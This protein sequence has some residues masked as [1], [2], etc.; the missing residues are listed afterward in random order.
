MIDFRLFVLTVFKMDEIL[1]INLSC[2][3][4]FLDFILVD[5]FCNS[6]LVVFSTQQADAI[7]KIS[8]LSRKLKLNKSL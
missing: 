3:V 5:E 7:T 6:F 4:Y 2:V 8:T 1:F